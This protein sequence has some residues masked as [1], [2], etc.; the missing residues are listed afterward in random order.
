MC[1]NKTVN[2]KKKMQQNHENISTQIIPHK[3]KG[4]K[5]EYVY[6]R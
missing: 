5:L 3:E 2:E 4:A 1:K 6:Y